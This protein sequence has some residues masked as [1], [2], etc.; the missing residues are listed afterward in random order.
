MFCIRQVKY[1][2]NILIDIQDKTMQLL[3][4]LII[5]YVKC[6][7]RPLKYI[8]KLMSQPQKNPISENYAAFQSKMTKT[9]DSAQWSKQ[10]V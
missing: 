1:E 4:K 9:L 5:G 6:I 3:R 7:K 8:N 2:I 10:E